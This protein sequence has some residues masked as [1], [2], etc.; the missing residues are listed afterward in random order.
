MP[1]SECLARAPKEDRT[2]SHDTI[3]GAAYD[4]MQERG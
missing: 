3:V 2:E 4:V 1:Q